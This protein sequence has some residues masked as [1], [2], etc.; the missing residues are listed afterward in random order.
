MLGKRSF[1]FHILPSASP[2][3]FLFSAGEKD[4]EHGE[5]TPFLLQGAGKCNLA[6][7]FGRRREF[8]V[9]EKSDSDGGHLSVPNFSLIMMMSLVGPVSL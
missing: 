9:D 3:E 1:C 7:S 5:S 8:S 6:V 4:K 2:T